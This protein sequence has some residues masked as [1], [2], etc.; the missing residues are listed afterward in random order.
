MVAVRK[1]DWR[2]SEHKALLDNPL[3]WKFEPLLIV[4]RSHGSALL[5]LKDINS[6]HS[7]K[8]VPP[9]SPQLITIIKPGLRDNLGLWS[10]ISKYHS[11]PSQSSWTNIF[12]GDQMVDASLAHPV[13][14]LGCQKPSPDRF[15]KGIYVGTFIHM[16]A[17]RVAGW[18]AYH[19][20]RRPSGGMGQRNSWPSSMIETTEGL[21]RA[22]RMGLS[23]SQPWIRRYPVF[24]S[25]LA[26]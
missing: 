1:I 26:M 24:H 12:W 3:F 6:F 22:S 7:H 8:T 15:P 21:G 14:T 11:H 18:Q 9:P 19:P 16:M 5:G 4:N 13:S 10:Y 23:H 20:L 17:Q 25:D 2:G